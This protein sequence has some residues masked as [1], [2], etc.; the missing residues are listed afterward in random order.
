MVLEPQRGAGLT[1]GRA[2][3]PL[4]SVRLHNHGESRQEFRDFNSAAL[5]GGLPPDHLELGAAASIINHQTG[6]C[7]LMSSP[8]VETAEAGP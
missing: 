6:C 1:R 7:S 2:L 3:K 8:F 4:V 5:I